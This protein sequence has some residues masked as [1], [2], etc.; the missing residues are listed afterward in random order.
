MLKF[1]TSEKEGDLKWEYLRYDYISILMC[2]RSALRSSCG[3]SAQT[4]S[5]KPE[6]ACQE[7]T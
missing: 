6:N 5:S 1:V 4:T 3:L 7:R 2:I